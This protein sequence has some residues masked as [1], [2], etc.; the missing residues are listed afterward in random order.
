MN[1]TREHLKK[2]TNF[3]RN[4]LWSVKFKWKGQVL[5]IYCQINFFFYNKSPINNGLK[6]Y[7]SQRKKA[8]LNKQHPESLM[9]FV[10]E[11]LVEPNNFWKNVFWGPIKQSWFLIAKRCI[12]LWLKNRM[13]KVGVGSL[14]F[15]HMSVRTLIYWS[16]LEGNLIY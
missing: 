1:F 10:G 9:N 3:S 13:R 12:Q 4:I 11:Y 8:L 15:W 2:L 14:S 7:T 6:C 5:H 16:I